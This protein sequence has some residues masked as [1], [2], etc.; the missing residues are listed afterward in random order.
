VAFPVRKSGLPSRSFVAIED[1]GDLSVTLFELG[2]VAGAI[3]KETMR[4]PRHE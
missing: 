3:A 2:R 1:Y 4:D